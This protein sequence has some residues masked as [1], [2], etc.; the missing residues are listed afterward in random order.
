MENASLYLPK[1]KVETYVEIDKRIKPKDLVHGK[2]NFNM[3]GT[4]VSIV[5]RF[6]TEATR[7]DE[8]Y[9]ILND[10]NNEIN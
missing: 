5:S 4:V 10:F 9:E 3:Y 7:T 2:H 8:M 1:E 6:L